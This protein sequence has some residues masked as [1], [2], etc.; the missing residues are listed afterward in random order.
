MSSAVAQ[1]ESA[2]AE[3]P[4]EDG[5]IT[6][7]VVVLLSAVAPPL[8]R[9]QLVDL[10]SY[11]GIAARPA[12]DAVDLLVPQIDPASRTPLSAAAARLEPRTEDGA[13]SLE[14]IPAEPPMPA[15][16]RTRTTEVPRHSRYLVAA[17]R[18]FQASPE[19]AT[20]ERER[21]YLAQHLAAV[22]RTREAAR[23]VDQAVSQ[24]R[25]SE[26]GWHAQLDA[27]TT[28]ECRAAHGSNF[29]AAS[30]PAI[31]YPGTLHGGTCRCRP[32]A[33]FREALRTDEAVTEGLK[34]ITG[35]HDVAF[36]RDAG[37]QLV[38]ELIASDGARS[39]LSA[40]HPGGS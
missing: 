2:P 38:V 40:I 23:R 16:S 10:L 28:P 11:L 35:S 27:K 1:P 30:P 39:V 4:I 14:L 12:G 8:M 18:R 3:T 33:P 7:I 25:S 20:V 29:Q 17:A 24:H 31:G 13:R 5:V 9:V 21:R 6:A 26:L 22:Q 15:Q 19:P 37:E 32:G 36:S 34:R